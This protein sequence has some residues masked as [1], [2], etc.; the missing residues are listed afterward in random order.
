VVVTSRADTAASGLAEL[1][2]G[3]A[4]T[5]AGHLQ[6]HL[7]LKPRSPELPLAY[8]ELLGMRVACAELVFEQEGAQFQRLAAPALLRRE[9]GVEL[10]KPARFGTARRRLLGNL[11][12]ERLV[13]LV[14][15]RKDEFARL[16][17]PEAVVD[18]HCRRLMEV[19]RTPM[20]AAAAGW[21]AFRLSEVHA[22]N[23]ARATATNLVEDGW[24]DAD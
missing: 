20:A 9:L 4:V 5:A 22:V 15:E 23:M 18:H 11:T 2:V 13:T 1:L 12:S 7:G 19:T 24:F 3:D 14:A 21:M 10:S 16:A 6:K 17:T 8:P